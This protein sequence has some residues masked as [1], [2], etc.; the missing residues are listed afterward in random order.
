MCDK[1]FTCPDIEHEIRFEA[2]NRH[3][4][5]RLP[6][7]IY[8]TGSWIDLAKILDRFFTF[9]FT[10]QYHL[11]GEVVIDDINVNTILHYI[12]E[13]ISEYE[14]VNKE[15]VEGH[16]DPEI[17]H[18]VVNHNNDNLFVATIDEDIYLKL[19]DMAKELHH[20]F[21][22]YKWDRYRVFAVCYE[23]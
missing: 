15:F 5:D 12:D 10:T 23:A 11:A 9:A 22:N 17:K 14:S 6:K 7:I 8:R 3:H 4:P 1:V 16:C 20:T 13:A 2:H 18:T 19:K 21:D